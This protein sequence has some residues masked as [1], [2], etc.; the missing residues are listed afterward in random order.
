ME[1]FA[2]R[3]KRISHSG[4]GDVE[5]EKEGIFTGAFCLNPFTGERIPIY[6]AN[7]V[8]M[9]Y[10][11]GAVMAVPAHDQ[12]DFEFARKY[13][14]PVRPVIHPRGATLAADDMTEA[15]TA[16]G[17]MAGSGDFSG[18]SSEE[19]R[20]RIAAFLQERDW[21]KGTVRYRLRDWG[22][23]RQRYWGAP[24]PVVHCEACG[25]VPVPL[26]E[27]PV[28]LPTNVE[29][30]GAGGSPLASLPEF[31]ETTCP[32]CQRPARRETDTMDT[33]VESFVVLR[34]LRLSRRGPSSPLDRKRT[35]Y[36][37]AVDPVRGRRRACGAAP[38]LRPVLYPRSGR[39]WLVCR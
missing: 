28:R 24:I 10:G 16:D 17:V 32:T 2:R 37:M 31:Y 11:T 36:W 14:L 38:A 5:M 1:E 35:D 6:L 22:I 4:R 12:R 19:G 26:D 39:P 13:D 33:F 30:T 23:S 29:F 18:L 27:L 9:E 8:L 3:V 25:M 20:S 15:Y 7:F 34:P 21:G